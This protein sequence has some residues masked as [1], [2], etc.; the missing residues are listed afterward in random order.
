MINTP[1]KDSPLPWVFVDAQ[2]STLDEPCTNSSDVGPKDTNIAPNIDLASF[3][4][5]VSGLRA[6]PIS[7]RH[8]LSMTEQRALAKRVAAFLDA[9]DDT[10][11]KTKDGTL[12]K[13]AWLATFDTFVDTHSEAME[14]ND[15]R[16]KAKIV[17]TALYDVAM[18][19]FAE[20]YEEFRSS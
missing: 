10:K 5:Q 16:K 8:Q 17:A 1:T 15:V 19:A 3:G 2:T 11:T 13:Y 14:E 9:L 20:M 4:Q 7:S 18:D 6:T 12:S